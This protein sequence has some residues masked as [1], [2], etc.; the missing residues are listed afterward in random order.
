MNVYDFDKTIYM[1][2]SS[3]DLIKSLYF[4]KPYLIF[5]CG[6]KSFIAA[7]KYFIFHKGRKED[8]KEVFFEILN[9]FDN[10]EKV[11]EDFWDK[12]IDGIKE[13][14]LKQKKDDDL[15]ISASPT[16]LIE[17]ICKRLNIKCL[18]SPLDLN[19]L[20]YE[21]KNCYGEEKVNV[22]KKYYDSQIDEFYSDSISDEPLALLA[23]KAYIV[24]KNEIKDWPRKD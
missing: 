16:F 20:K 21:G 14:Y 17:P 22:F 23:K 5:T 8:A 7:T 6:I 19:T 18:A 1:N 13:F 3:I 9:H 2:D 10:K 15:I 24:D 12:H 4:K 11:I